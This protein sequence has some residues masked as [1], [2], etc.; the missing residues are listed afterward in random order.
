ME[1]DAGR[2][3]PSE[4]RCVRFIFCTCHHHHHHHLLLLL[5]LLLFCVV[6]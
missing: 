4:L 2:E 3:N 5:L 1:E 6:S